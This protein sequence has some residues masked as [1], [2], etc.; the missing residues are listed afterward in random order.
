MITT[1]TRRRSTALTVPLVLGAALTGCADDH[2]DYQTDYANHRPLR[3]TGHPST[4]SLGTVQKVVWRLAD[5]DADGLAALDSEGGDAKPA[6]RA[7]IKAYGEAAAR[8][9]V[10]AD[11]DEEGS[12]RQ[13]V[14]LHFTGPERTQRVTVRIGGNDTWGIVLANPS[15][16]RTLRGS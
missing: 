15:P 2:L 11:F 6:A 13:E 16:R 14:V 7:W 5:G 10:T 9:E 3:V 8:D 4:G 12:V 1:S